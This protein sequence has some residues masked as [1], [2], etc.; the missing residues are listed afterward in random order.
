MATM[1]EKLKTNRE[2]RGPR[3]DQARQRYYAA[4]LAWWHANRAEMDGTANYAKV[5]A[6][7]ARDSAWAILE[8]LDA[9]ETF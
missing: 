7:I 4:N 2:A 8:Q 5:V 1:K 6:G 9:P 3:I